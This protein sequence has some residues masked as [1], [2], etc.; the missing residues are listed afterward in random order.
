MNLRISPDKY[1]TIL[2]AIIAIYGLYCLYN[3]FR[4]ARDNYLFFNQLLIPSGYAVRDCK[5]PREYMRFIKPRLVFA[6]LLFVAC[7]AAIILCAQLLELSV[8]AYWIM[9]GAAAFL[10]LLFCGYLI[11]TRRKFWE[12]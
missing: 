7:G 6:G 12:D 10:I 1:F 11:F 5:R 2:G 8:T 4:L 3:W 9:V